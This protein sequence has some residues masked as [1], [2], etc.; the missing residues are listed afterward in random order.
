MTTKE[1][2]FY[3]TEDSRTG[4]FIYTYDKPPNDDDELTPD[5]ENVQSNEDDDVTPDDAFNVTFELPKKGDVRLYIVNEF[6][7]H[8][9]WFKDIKENEY[10]ENIYLKIFSQ[11]HDCL[12]F[13][14]SG[15]TGNWRQEG[16]YPK[17]SKE[18]KELPNILKKEELKE[19]ERSVGWYFFNVIDSDGEN[20]ST[21]VLMQ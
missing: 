7:E 15:Y 8:I 21:N 11:I 3:M 9:F 4:A 18:I 12:P 16:E 20:I 2:W 14:I 6:P 19:M 1:Y 5:N 17:I 13:K 10:N